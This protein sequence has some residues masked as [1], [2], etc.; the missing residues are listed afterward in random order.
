M[1]DITLS[2][3][4]QDFNRLT[5]A[6]LQWCYPGGRN[7][8][9]EQA[10]RFETLDDSEEI[11]WTYRYVVWVGVDWANVL[12]ARAYLDSIGKPC[13]VLWD[14]AFNPDPSWI[15]LTDYATSHWAQHEE[16]ATPEVPDTVSDMPSPART[17]HHPRGALPVP[18]EHEFDRI[19]RELAEGD[20]ATLHL[21]PD[22][23]V[24]FTVRESEH[25]PGEKLLHTELVTGD[26]HQAT[27][28]LTAC[29]ILPPDVP[30]GGGVYTA[31]VELWNAIPEAVENFTLSQMAIGPS[32]RDGHKK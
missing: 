17:D 31:V 1:P 2:M 25:S 6:S 23:H 8:W 15:I 30:W 7:D 16:T 5:H 26:Y 20:T 21:T 32:V 4:E 10:H 18:D 3:D 12:F 19:A 22:A 13:Q 29:P 11:N 28:T 24:A 9:V 27:L 14:M